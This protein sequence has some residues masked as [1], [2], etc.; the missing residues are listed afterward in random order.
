[1]IH[2]LDKIFKPKSIAVVGA[3]TKEKSVGHSIFK[4][5]V[6]N[7]FQGNVY[8]INP[9]AGE[10]LGHKAYPALADLPEK[11]DL[12]V[13]VVPSK[14]VPSVV[15]ECGQAGVGG[16]II[17]SAGFKEAGE[18][19]E[20][21]VEAILITCRKY[22]MRLI[23]PN[24]LGTINP[25]LGMNATFASRMALPGNIAFISQSGALCSSILDWACEQNVGFSHFVSIGSMVDIGFAELIDY[26]GM[27]QETSCILI[28]MES[29]TEA[30]K[31]MSAAR[32]FARSK[33]IIILK[34]GRSLAGS[35]AAMSHTGTLAG[36]DAAFD[37]AF[38]RSGCV[39]V[40]TISQLFNCAQALS[41]QP[42]RR[43]NRLAI[44]TN[45][46]GP[47]VLATDYLITRGGE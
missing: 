36:N 1:M 39:R 10:L 23:G 3:S 25:K 6:D 33:P 32:A 37:A 7:Q 17:I 41:M 34:A 44:V 43:G 16:L 21:M 42:R 22:K 15:E 11:V 5:L 8:P 13:I 26:F 19:G 28:Y 27:D 35:K 45:A 24:C 18:E 2:Q 29:L 38:K 14:L 30:R 12:A 9:K 40:E 47:G 20:K 46:G 31:F 4:N